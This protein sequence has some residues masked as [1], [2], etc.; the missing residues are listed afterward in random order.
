L[1]WDPRSGLK[2]FVDLDLVDPDSSPVT[3]ER[4]Q[5]DTD[6]THAY[7]GADVMRAN[8]G[9]ATVDDVEFW[10]GERSKL[11]EMDF[12]QRGTHNS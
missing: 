7:L 8:H 6:G 2:T 11:V 12:L 1:S 4:R 3:G 5:V 10:F 9:S